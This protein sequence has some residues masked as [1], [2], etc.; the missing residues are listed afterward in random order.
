MRF[1]LLQYFAFCTIILSL[2]WIAIQSF[3]F[4]K[5]SSPLFPPQS[6]IKTSREYSV[7][8]LVKD[9]FAKGT[10]ENISNVRAIGNINGIGYFEQGSSIIGM[11]RGIILSTG[12]ISNAE[13]PNTNT[14]MSGNFNDPAGDPDLEMLAANRMFDAVGLEFDFVPLDSFV[15]FRYVFASEEYCEFVGSVYNDVFGFFIS[16]PG[17]NGTFINNAKNVALIP[18]TADYVAINSVNHTYNSPYFVRNELARD[19]QECG[20]AP[21]A[22]SP[23]WQL[24]EYDGFTRQLT[25]SLQLI[26]CQTYHIRLVVSDVADKYYDSAVFLEAESFN[27]G[28]TV[29]ISPKVTNTNENIALEG[30]SDAFFVFERSETEN[31]DKAL[32]VNFKIAPSSTAVET[33]DFERLPR[34]ITIPPREQLVK[35]PVHFL[36]DGIAEPP[37]HLTIELDI[38]CACYIGTATLQV[39]D[40]PGVQIELLSTD[41][42]KNASALL[43]PIITGGTPPY[44]YRWSNG[45]LTE[46]LSISAAAASTYSITVTDRCGNTASD[47]ARIS[48]VE[49]PMATLSGYAE[50]CS[51]D[52]AYLEV[53]F[54]GTPPWRFSYLINGMAQG[55]FENILPNQFSFPVTQQGV[56]SIGKINDRN[57]EGTSRGFGELVLTDVNIEPTVQHVSCSDGNDGSINVQ[58]YGG[59]PPYRYRWAHSSLENPAL[60]GLSEGIYTLSVTDAEGCTGSFDIEVQAP[61]ALQAVVFTCEDLTDPDF[62]FSAKGGT[63]PY[64]YSVD[65]IFFEKE[66]IFERLLPGETYAL[67]V[68]DANGCYLEQTLSMPPVYDKMVELPATMEVKIGSVYAIQPK[69]NLP[70]ALIANIRWLPNTYLSCLDCLVPQAQAYTDQQYTI[71]LTDIF[72]CTGEASIQIKVNKEVD[73]FIPDAFSPTGNLINDRFTIFANPQ[74]VQQVRSFQ[75]FDR[76]G[77]LVFEQRDFPINDE[78]YGWDGTVRGRL[79]NPG[80]FTYLARLT[81]IDGS[82]TLRKGQTMLMR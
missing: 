28:G 6:G 64:Q 40:A 53:V 48:L 41:V 63:P 74:Q 20:I 60:Q 67:T 35:L 79:S 23:Y 31:I 11:E 71:R 39:Q 82:E 65:G 70:E 56:Y 4:L 10:C 81:L 69:L 78:Q 45:A 76:W 66:S 52:T 8:A 73:V 72:G 61:Q 16:G 21:L 43:K 1:I 51:G 30:C 27:I 14:D 2:G 55:T 15:Q 17:I 62:Q 25:A 5:P 24:I 42:C 22:N 80:V 34:A 68:M 32:T 26:P 33:I 59:L 44:R 18:G 46:S 13:G 37:K 58:A 36:N 9:I 47:T 38:P 7:E 12:P 54:T 57:C 50:I 3:D 29:A 19:A 77:N 49:A 75:V